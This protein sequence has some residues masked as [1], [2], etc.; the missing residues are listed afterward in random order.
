MM[1][2]K[3][4]ANGQR[5]SAERGLNKFQ[6]PAIGPYLIVGTRRATKESIT[7]AVSTTAMPARILLT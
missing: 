3:N 1:V 6:V 5:T 2:A 4:H 7:A